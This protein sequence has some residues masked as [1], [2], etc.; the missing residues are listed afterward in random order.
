MLSREPVWKKYGTPLAG[1]G[2]GRKDR[3]P[4]PV[5]EEREKIQKIQEIHYPG[6]TVNT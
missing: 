5:E 3:G 1:P 4:L 2:N 6:V